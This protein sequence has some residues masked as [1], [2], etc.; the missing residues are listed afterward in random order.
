VEVACTTCY[1]MK[2]LRPIKLGFDTFLTQDSLLKIVTSSFV[3]PSCGTGLQESEVRPF[4]DPWAFHVA[5]LTRP[6]AVY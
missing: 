5:R 4:V 3:T 6:Q 2:S 1:P